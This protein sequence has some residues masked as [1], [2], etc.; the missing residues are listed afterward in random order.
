MDNV[1]AD[2]EAAVLNPQHPPFFNAYIHGAQHHD[3][4]FF[5]R[6][7]VGALPQID[8]PEEVGL[9]NFSGADW[10][11][12]IWYS[13]HFKTEL[14][15]HTASSQEDKRLFTVHKYTMEVVIAK[16]NHLFTRATL[17]YSPLV[18]GERV[19]KFGLLPNLRVTRVTDDNGKDIHY[20]QEDRKHDGSF[21]VILDQ[22][23]P[24][25][26]THTMT[27]EYAGDKVLTDVGNGNYFVR[28]R[29]SWYPNL[30]NV[31]FW[32]EGAV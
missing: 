25:G 21:Y 32:R 11:D 16:N 27:I 13:N 8:S 9:V 17:S 15:A 29:E 14:E 23:A 28:A 10:D 18:P 12:G 6:T 30:G 2:V 4:R 5:V 7:R 24:V 20:I 1:D 3:L 19:V 22:G 26:S 31:A